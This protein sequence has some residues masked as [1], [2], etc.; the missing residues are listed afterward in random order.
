MRSF[1]QAARVK[2]GSRWRVC[3]YDRILWN[4]VRNH[5]SFIPAV[6]APRSDFSIRESCPM[7]RTMKELGKEGL[8]CPVGFGIA[9]YV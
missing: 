9:Y 8:I 5:F 1:G 3:V 4:Y 6:S 2:I 7:C